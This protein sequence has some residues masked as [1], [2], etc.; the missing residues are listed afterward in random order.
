MSSEP[1][2][3]ITPEEYI[4]R[5]LAAESKHEYVHGEMVAMA[6]GSLRHSVISLNIAGEL[7]NRLRGSRCTVFNLDARVCV[8]WGELITY[9]DVTVVCGP[10][11]LDERLPHTLL[12]PPSSLRFFPH[13]REIMIAARRAVCSGCC[14]LSPNT[15]CVEQDTVEIEHYRRLPNGHWDLATIRE[16]DAVLTLESV[17]CDLPVA[18]IYSGLEMLDAPVA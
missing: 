15:S 9:P 11:Q 6:G 8:Q 5:E 14:P 16:R 10:P 2:S 13:P 12:M 1:V 17:H 18:E 3:Y 7:R 4:A